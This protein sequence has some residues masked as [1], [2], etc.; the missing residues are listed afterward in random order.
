MRAEFC[1]FESNAP[2]LKANFYKPYVDM[3]VAGQIL[4]FYMP[5]RLAL[6]VE[7][8]HWNECSNVTFRLP[9]S[10]FFNQQ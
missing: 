9:G 3:L 2:G 6:F 5:K 7:N 8:E 1:I 4:H 10:L